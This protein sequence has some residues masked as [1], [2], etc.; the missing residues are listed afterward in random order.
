[1]RSGS[2]HLVGKT[3]LIKNEIKNT[4]FGVF[5]AI[6]RSK[7]N[8]YLYH[9]FNSSLF[10][11]QSTGYLTT[12]INQLTNNNLNNIVT[13]LPPADEQAQIVD[14]L[15][16]E[17]GKID[18]LIA[19][20]ERLIECLKEK[21]TALIA[22]A[23]TKGLNPNV[24]L[25]PSGVEWLGDVPEHWKV[26]SLRYLF[27]IKAGGDLK[28]EFYAEEKS[29]SH[30]YPIYTNSIKSDE[31]Y[32]F[33]S[34]PFFK[35][36]TITVTGRGEIGYATYRDHEYDAIIRLLVLT[37]KKKAP[38]KYY[39]Y[40]INSIIKFLGGSTA[41]SQLSTE[42]IS[43]YKVFSPPPPEQQA[44]VEYLDL[45]TR[46]I[47]DLIDKV[48]QAIEKLKEYRTALISAAVTGKID[49]REGVA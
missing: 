25:K 49:V 47:D 27:N 19:K 3:V 38:C 15:D 44:I 16:R 26:V 9:V 1:V 24:R 4:T 29:E 10:K 30:P 35:S 13:P 20:K 5:M 48:V 14:F 36:N 41:V 18:E 37:P 21:R 7:I 43:P 46:K 33:S 12:T 22:R 34:K 2:R 42:Q 31:A 6:F 17:T 11:Y 23:V 32:G 39:V 40:F 8:R 28:E 45:E